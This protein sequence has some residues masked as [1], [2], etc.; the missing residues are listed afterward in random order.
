M[1]WDGE[2]ELRGRAGGSGCT[3]ALWQ[4]GSCGSSFTNWDGSGL[5]VL[6]VGRGGGSSDTPVPSHS[7]SALG[8]RQEALPPHSLH[9]SRG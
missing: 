4:G 3:L 8:P 6:G 2:P 7:L 1:S 5:A 9:P